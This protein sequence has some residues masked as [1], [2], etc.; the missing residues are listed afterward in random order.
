[1]MKFRLLTKMLLVAAALTV[2]VNGAWGAAGDY[3][4]NLT[5][6]TGTVGNTDGSSLF[7]NAHSMEYALQDNGTYTI[8]F[9]NHGGPNRWSSFVL[10]INNGTASYNNLG[11]TEYVVLRA[12]NYGWGTYYDGD[13][14]TNTFAQPEGS[15]K[16]WEEDYA[17]A[18]ADAYVVMKISRSGTTISMTATITPTNAS[19]SPW[20]YSW[21]NTMA[22]ATGD[23]GFEFTTDESYMVI[24]SSTQTLKTVVKSWDFTIMSR[25]A[26]KVN[27]DYSTTTT[28]VNNLPC[29][30]GINDFAGLAFQGADKFQIYGD[31]VGLYNGN[32]GGRQICVLNL[33]KDDHVTVVASAGTINNLANC[34]EITSG[35][36]TGTYVLNVKADGAIAFKSDPR[37]NYVYSIVVT[38]EIEAGTCVNPTYSIIAADGTNRKFTLTCET[39]NST[40]YYSET[41]KAIGDEGW[42]I[43][44]GVVST[45][46][47]TI[48]TYAATTQAN[49]E[50]ISFETGA[51]TAITLNAPSLSKTAYANNQY[52]VSIYSNQTTI[53]GAPVATI[54]Y[55]I[56]GGED[57]TYTAPFTVDEGS[58]VV[59]YT[60]ATGY[61]QSSNVTLTTAARPTGLTEVWTQDYTNL[62]SDETGAQQITLTNT[63]GGDFTVDETPY[64]NITGYGSTVLELNPN[65]GLNTSSY[66]YL[67]TNGN[68]SGIL[69]NANNSGSTGYI[70]INNLLVGDQIVITTNGNSLNATSGVTLESDLSTTSEYIFTATA[71]K[72]S[73]L[74]NHG[75]Y[76]YVKSI[77]V[78]RVP[79]SVAI[80]DA[81]WAT[82]YT[83]RALDFSGVEGLTAY[84]AICSD[85]KVTLTKVDDVP[86]NTGVVL[87]GA[88]GSYSIPVITSSTTD[89]GDLLGSATDATPWNSIS[90]S[91]LYMLKMVYN[92]EKKKDLAQFVPVTSG[93]I[94]AGKAYLAVAGNGIRSLNVELSDE[95]TGIADIER[96]GTK[97]EGIYNLRGQRVSQPTKGLYIM[98]DRKVIIK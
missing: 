65:V 26:L 22:N 3:V 76:N 57:Q 21:S 84:T 45:S 77:T 86:A 74:F 44:N 96:A 64:Y 29:N 97:Q 2:G 27:E 93:S 89:K 6:P 54:K 83:D 80:S 68:N 60:T 31:N 33:K 73:V 62:V 48:W 71:T 90:G 92:E 15:E 5:T 34:T 98:G 18:L 55:A 37:Y 52:T 51:G 12:D 61:T 85:S 19:Y 58:T 72:A 66:F 41:E 7:W 94:P 59:A 47:A 95:V 39:E 70:G 63:E 69:K 79:A 81:G 40:I 78:N 10:V 50:I 38:R 56:D 67:R 75:T 25:H 13:K 43:Y 14:F 49:S 11:G 32:S 23:V 24:S 30:N 9:E 53:L 4:S 91:T 82:L 88:E 17:A 46:A 20:T 35:A 36:N 16:S 8:E 42:F 87:K 28:T 1:M